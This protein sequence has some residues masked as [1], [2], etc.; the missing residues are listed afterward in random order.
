MKTTLEYY[1]RHAEDYVR[2]TA[3][4][5]FADLQNRFLEILPDGGRILDF[6]CGSGRDAKYFC[7]RGYIVDAVDGSAA[8][9]EAAEKRIG[10]PVRRMLFEEL[11]AV[12]IYDGIWACASVLHVTPEKLP[13][14]FRRMAEALKPAGVLYVSFKYGTFS[15]MRNGR[16]FTDLTEESLLSLAEQSGFHAEEIWKTGDVRVNRGQ[17][18]WLNAILRKTDRHA[19]VAEK[20]ENGG[21]H[22]E[23]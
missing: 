18:L 20:G 11:D 5:P 8:L 14:I 9:C 7:D 2:D 19:A 4:V 23:S 6:G 15:G 13:E 16:Y 10:R 1:E 22:Y 12:E 17:E 3:D 21:R